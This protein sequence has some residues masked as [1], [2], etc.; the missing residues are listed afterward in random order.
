[1][2]TWWLLNW[3]STAVVLLGI[4]LGPAMVWSVHKDIKRMKD[5]GKF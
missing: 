2:F 4:V 3:L 1:M 5:E